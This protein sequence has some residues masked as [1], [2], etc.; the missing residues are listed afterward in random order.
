MVIALK[1]WFLKLPSVTPISLQRSFTSG[2]ILFVNPLGNLDT[3]PLE[4]Y[5]YSH[6][7]T[8]INFYMFLAIDLCT[9]HTV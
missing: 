6:A 1:D 4:L 9:F 2:H 3:K 5:A 7:C 8:L